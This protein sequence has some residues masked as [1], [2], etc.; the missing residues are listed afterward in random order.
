MAQLTDASNAG[1]ISKAD[2][3]LEEENALTHAMSEASV[4]VVKALLSSK[5]Y[6]VDDVPGEESAALCALRGLWD[7]KRRDRAI[8]I[9]FLVKEHG[10]KISSKE[11][12]QHCFEM[13]DDALMNLLIEKGDVQPED[14]PKD[15]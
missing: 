14:V 12:A 5:L 7:S 3:V 1:Y 4:K 8:A 15:K 9:Y 2:A 10:A 6:T 13:G 11:L